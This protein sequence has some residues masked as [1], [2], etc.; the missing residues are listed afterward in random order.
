VSGEVRVLK[1]SDEPP[2]YTV[3]S[4]AQLLS[5][6]P[7]TVK[8]MIRDGEIASYKIRD[9]RRIAKADVDSYLAEH[10]EDRRNAA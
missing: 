9:S 3:A 2:F 7:K 1:R 8:N 6:T 5:V 10:R 4:L